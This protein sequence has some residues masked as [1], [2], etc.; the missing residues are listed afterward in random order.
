MHKS[1]LRVFLMSTKFLPF[2]NGDFRDV[3]GDP[4]G[5]LGGSL[6]GQEASDSIARGFLGSVLEGVFDFC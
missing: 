4:R 1:E 5:A 6:G 2:F 3:L